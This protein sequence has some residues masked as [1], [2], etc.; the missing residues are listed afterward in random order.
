[1][2][3]TIT[4][5]ATQVRNMTADAMLRDLA[6]VLRLA[7]SVKSELMAERAMTACQQPLFPPVEPEACAV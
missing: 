1:M 7:K 4:G 6:Y 3:K 5:Q 2:T